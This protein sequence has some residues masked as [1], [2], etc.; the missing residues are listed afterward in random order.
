[1]QSCLH[2]VCISCVGNINDFAFKLGVDIPKVRVE[3]YEVWNTSVHCLAVQIKNIPPA[4]SLDVA[5]QIDPQDSYMK[6]A[7]YQRPN[8]ISI[9]CLDE[10]SSQRQSRW[11][12]AW[13]QEQTRSRQQR[14]AWKWEQSK[15]VLWCFPLEVYSSQLNCVL[16]MVSTYSM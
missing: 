15:P 13:R 6:E 1:M 10:V 3:N 7:D 8:S 14:L 9:L 12:A 4:L 16:K 5:S 11:E 2:S